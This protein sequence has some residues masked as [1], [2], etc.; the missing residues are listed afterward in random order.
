M[1]VLGDGTVT[2]VHLDYES[3]DFIY[4]ISVLRKEAREPLYPC[5]HVPAW[6]EGTIRG[7]GSKPSP[8]TDPAAVFTMHFQ[9]RD[10]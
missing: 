6:P 5:H 10:L 7:P 4:G 2:G 9:T 1:L 3:G 8:D